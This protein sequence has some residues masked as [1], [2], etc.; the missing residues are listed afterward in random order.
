MGVEAYG[1]GGNSQERH[2]SE[3]IQEMM[4]ELVMKVI[5]LANILFNL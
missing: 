3:K 5:T 4:Y 1:Q 2:R